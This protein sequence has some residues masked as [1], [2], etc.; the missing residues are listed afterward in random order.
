MYEMVVDLPIS[1][2]EAKA[3]AT[4]EQ[5]Q[6]GYDLGQFDAQQ[7]NSLLVCVTEVHNETDLNR[8]VDVLT[9]V[10]ATCAAEV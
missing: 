5:V 1:A 8:Y 2:K 10:L 9:K 7:A 4:K 6:L 3:L